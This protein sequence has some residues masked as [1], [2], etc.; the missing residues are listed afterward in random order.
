MLGDDS[1][2]KLKG[3]DPGLVAQFMAANPLDS[4]ILVRALCSFAYFRW[5]ICQDRLG[6]EY[7]LLRQNTILNPTGSPRQARDRIRFIAAKYHFE[8]DQFTKTG[9]GHSSI[10][11]GIQSCRYLCLGCR[12]LCRCLARNEVFACLRCSPPSTA[13]LL[14][15]HRRTSMVTT[16]T[17]LKSERN[18]W[19]RA[20][21]TGLYPR[22]P[23]TSEHRCQLCVSLVS[24]AA[25][26]CAPGMLLAQK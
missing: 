14:S 18:C 8:P 20:A 11:V 3:D 22:Q 23:S 21:T 7:V 19:T 26:V 13:G 1:C 2:F 24:Q 4:D 12:L 9:S 15:T 10:Y 5:L 25:R 6:T 16:G 17:C